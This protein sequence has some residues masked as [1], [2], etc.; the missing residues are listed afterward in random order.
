MI[1]LLQ[2]FRGVYQWKDFENLLNTWWT[3]D[4]LSGLLF[5]SQCINYVDV[6]P[7]APD[8]TELYHILKDN[9]H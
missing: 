8:I 1:T 6:I 7:T 9:T 5:V 2:A 3:Y 4:V